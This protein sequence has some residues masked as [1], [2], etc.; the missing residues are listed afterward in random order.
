MNR[1]KLAQTATTGALILVAIAAAYPRP[2]WSETDKPTNAACLKC[3]VG[4]KDEM[5]AAV[6]E[7]E[8]VACTKCHGPSLSHMQDDTRSAKPDV[9][10]GRSEIKPYCKECH[11]MHHHPEKVAAFRA[12]WLGKRRENGR[13]ITAAA[14]CTDCH[15]KHNAVKAGAASGEWATLFNGKDLTGW[16]AEG[17]ASWEVADGHLVGRQ[18]AGNA[19]GDLFTEQEF[20]DFELKVTFRMAW[21]GNS[22]VWFRYQVPDRSYQADILEYE[23]PVCYAGSLYCPGKM[24]LAMNEDPDLVNRDGWNTL[25]ITAQG[26]HLVVKLNDVVT[27]DVREGS[28]D[29][30]RIGFQIHAGDQFKDMR[31]TVREIRIRSLG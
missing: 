1:R 24:F 26:D 29:K 13:L 7:E 5:I 31:I 17:D 21:P 16:V 8:S 6:H 11:P 4:L 27:G 9:L 20:G 3:H 12:K 2:A 18:G 19:P 10:F 15:G 23:N 22:G 28:F 30:G 14:I 25:A